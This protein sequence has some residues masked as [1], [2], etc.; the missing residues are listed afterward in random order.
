MFRPLLLA[1]A[2]TV[3]AA[4]A[5][6]PNVDVEAPQGLSDSE[7]AEVVDFVVG[8]AV[9]AL[10]H[11]AGHMMMERLGVDAAGGEQTADD[12]AV[13]TLLEPRTGAG[14]Q[15]LVDAVDSWML[16][17]HLTASAGA[18]AIGLPDRHS[19]DADRANAIVCNMVGS[20]PKDFADIA[21]AAALTPA[22]RANCSA[23]YQQKRAL[24]SNALKPVQREPGGPLS[25]IPVVYEP[26]T[27]NEVA[28]LTILHDNKVLEEVA[29]RLAN[30]F[31][32]A[33]PPTLRA[34]SCGA[35]TSSYDPARNEIVLCYELSSYH[36]EL[37][38]R[39]IQGR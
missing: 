29:T 14:D 32:L 24:W 7:M 18:D 30:D 23:S 9:F 13:M 36:A 1:F 3:S 26:P 5:A 8:N 10:Y 4:H 37:I 11:Q 6:T 25:V 22:T 39:D 16:S 33:K 17:N 15:T 28:E 38:V 34:K 35:V 2:L 20:N 12:F 21:E 27:G 31:T 19:V